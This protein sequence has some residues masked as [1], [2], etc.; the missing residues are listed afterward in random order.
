MGHSQASSGL[1]GV[2]MFR[3][4]FYT[5]SHLGA[6]AIGFAL[7]I[8]FLPILI[9]PLA[10]DTAMLQQTAQNAVFSTDLRRDLKGSDFLH[11][12]EGK[13]S[14]SPTQI[15]LEG[16]LAP[17]PDYKLYLVTAFADDEAGFLPLKADALLVGDIKT[18][19][20]FAVPLPEGTDLASYNTVLI[21]CE[22]FGEFIS[23]GQYR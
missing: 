3:K 12:G 6:L 13:V 4:I 10:P 22:T 7:G 5:L 23:A 1:K 15:V 18:F 19:K 11:W 9:A 2:L 21:W 17:G 16:G 14:L 20:G 8:Y